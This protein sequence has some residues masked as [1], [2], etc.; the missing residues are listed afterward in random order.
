M[1]DIE[2]GQARPGRRLSVLFVSGTLQR[3]GAERVLSVL[4]NALVATDAVTVL[5]IDSIRP[6]EYPL[7]TGVTRRALGMVDASTGVIDAIR[8][9]VRRVTA[10]RAAVRE[11]RPDVIVSFIHAVNVVTILATR[12]LGIPVVVS[13]RCDP[14]MEPLGLSWRVLRR[15][16]YPRASV[17]VCQTE[18]V[19]RWMQAF[20]PVGRVVT[21]ANPVGPQFVAADVEP[22]APTGE[23]PFIVA[24][25]R[26]VAQK[27]FDRLIRA[28]AM[29]QARHA[30]RLVIIGEG[31]DAGSLAALARSLG[32][33]ERVEFTG[34]LAQPERVVRRATMFVLASRY[35]GF[36]NV[37]LEAMALGRCVLAFDCQ[38]G[39]GDIISDGE[40][41]LLV[42][43]GDVAA[44]AAAMDR[45][46]EDE[47]LRHSLAARALQVRIRYGQAAIA[48]TWRALIE[49][50][51]S[52]APA[53]GA[54]ERAL[55]E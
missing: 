54:Q 53:G 34:R 14:R 16:L 19:S 46:A 9:N 37:L 44:L 24:V 1:S 12:G 27:G 48:G 26:L 31:P 50:R 30:L 25:G 10:L 2:G 49:D 23:P 42:R 29:A 43:D 21:I 41:G 28:Y 17:V 18:S 52:M 22:T 32:V 38:S 15:V 47:V 33:A 55:H 35:E 3:G 8:G 13:E 51:T 20:V 4:A 11:I 36:P 40:N 45:V 39:P 5:T 7:A 6:D